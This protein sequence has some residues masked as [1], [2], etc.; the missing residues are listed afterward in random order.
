[1][2]GDLLRVSVMETLG[3]VVSVAEQT[4]RLLPESHFTALRA[5]CKWPGLGQ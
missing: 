2:L 1:M 4:P 5:G 3:S